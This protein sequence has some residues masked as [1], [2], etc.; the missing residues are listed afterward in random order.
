M[1]KIFFVIEPMNFVVSGV[2]ASK[3]MEYFQ[4]FIF[5]R[6]KEKREGGREGERERGRERE[7]LNGM[8]TALV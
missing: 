4:G 5:E 2:K 3:D 7:R 6:E 8:R 1:H